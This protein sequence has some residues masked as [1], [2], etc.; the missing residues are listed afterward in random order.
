[1]IDFGREV[2]GNLAL[3]AGR[4]WLV[5]NG[6]GG[7][8]SGTVA[9]LLTRRYH[10]LLIA[11][12]RP[13]LGRTLLLTK[14]DETA[15]YDGHTYPLFANR[16][17]VPI[18]ALGHERGREWAGIEP[19]GF[20]HLERFHLE[21][22]TPLW[23]FACADALV[24]K[25]VW[26]QPGANTTYIRYDLRRATAPLALSVKAIVNYRDHHGNTYAGDWQ[27]R[28]EPLAHG[29]QVMAFEGAAPLYLLSDR[30]EAIPPARMVPR[31]LPER[32]EIS[33]TGCPG[34][35]PLCR[36]FPRRVAP[37]RVAHH[38][39]QH[40]SDTEPGGCIGLRRAASIRTGTGEAER[41]HRRARLGAALDFGR[42]PVHRPAR[43]A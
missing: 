7:Y 2:S 5:T 39:C 20:H 37:W 28:V 23:I 30:A 36:S 25:R 6:I 13:P 17:A 12:L 15:T 1:M 31:L 33:R 34:R 18:P 27:M 22:T 3:S 16:W 19:I 21:G 24:E 14:L 29:L 10:G 8:A 41:P 11:A 35:Q 32:R 40:R 38:C 26:M 43:V 9:G 42:R 4:A